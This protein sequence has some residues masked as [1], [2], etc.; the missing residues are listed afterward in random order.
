M[1][2]LWESHSSLNN[3]KDPLQRTLGYSCKEQFD[4]VRTLRDAKPPTEEGI[5]HNAF[6][7]KVTTERRASFETD[8]G[9]EEILLICSVKT[10]RLV[11]NP[12]EEGN[13][14]TTLSD[15]LQS[16]RRSGLNRLSGRSLMLF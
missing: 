13:S 8:N 3:K 2:E 11:E 10:V 1:S 5:R 16:H 14:S 7:E 9:R 6:L 12:I 15:S 4:S